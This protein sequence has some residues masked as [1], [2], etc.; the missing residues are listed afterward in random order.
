[1]KP[2]DFDQMFASLRLNL[3]PALQRV[4]QFKKL[5][6]EASKTTEDNSFQ[7]QEQIKRHF[8]QMIGREELKDDEDHLLNELETKRKE[9]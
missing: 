6:R 9:A 4:K 7:V 1:M 8:E 5:V 3:D 2:L